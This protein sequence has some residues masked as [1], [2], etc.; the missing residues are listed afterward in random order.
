MDGLGSS[1]NRAE[2]ARARLK[3]TARR[4]L[5]AHFD[6]SFDISQQGWKRELRGGPPERALIVERDGVPKHQPAKRK[7]SARQIIGKMGEPGVDPAEQQRHC[8]RARAIDG[9]VEGIAQETRR[10]HVREETDM[11]MGRLLIGQ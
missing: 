1:R 2:S 5:Q 3:P 9:G 7:A 8:G 6:Q 10:A 11:G 4:R